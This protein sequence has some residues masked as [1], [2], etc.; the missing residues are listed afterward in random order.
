[1]KKVVY[2]VLLS[3]LGCAFNTKASTEDSAAFDRLERKAARFFENAEWPNAN[4]MYVLM[5]DQR[6]QDRNIYSAAIVS[7]IMAGDTA[8]ALDLIPR[9][10]SNLIPI[11]TVLTEVQRTSFSIGRGDLYENFL[12]KTRSEYPWYSRVINN[13]LLN[14][15][16]FRDNGPELVKYATIMLGGLPNDRRF[17]RLLARGQLLSGHILQAVETWH[18]IATFYPTDYDNLL[19]LAN[20]YATVGD[21]S[22]AVEWFRRADA[23]RSTPYVTDYLRSHAH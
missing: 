3:L 6:P 13:Y 15:Y 12:L 7:N 4:A 8:R 19:D 23:I 20:Y 1:M 2:I 16:D 14:Y 9:A 18:K 10:L 5:L 17:L 11:D 21:T 22:N